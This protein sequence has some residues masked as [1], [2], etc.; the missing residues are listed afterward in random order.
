MT[1]DAYDA[2]DAAFRNNTIGTADDATLQAWLIV[3]ANE[4]IQNS[5]IQQAAVIR[6]LTLNHILLERHLSALD[7]K[8]TV[9]QYLVIGLTAAALLATGVQTVIAVRAERRASASPL[10][11][12]PAAAPPGATTAPMH[13][14]ATTAA[15]PS[16]RISAPTVAESSAL[17]NPK[18]TRQ[19]SPRAK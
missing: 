9:T 1:T 16:M 7:R 12:T 3:L 14:P 18:A 19:P 5:N 6:G 15:P 10:R 2:V 8:N 4:S 17:H 13:H 11:A